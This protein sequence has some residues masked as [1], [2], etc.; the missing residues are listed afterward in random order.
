MFSRRFRDRLTA[1]TSSTASKGTTEPTTFT[2]KEPD[3]DLP[4]RD[5]YGPREEDRPDVAQQGKTYE[6]VVHP[7][8]TTGPSDAD[9]KRIFGFGPDDPNVRVRRVSCA[10]LHGR[11]QALQ[12]VLDEMEAMFDAPDL[13][14]PDPD[15]VTE[16]DKAIMDV[17]FEVVQ[18]VMRAMK[19]HGPMR[20]PHEGYAVLKEEVDELWDEIKSDRGHFATA[21][22]EAIQVAAMAMRYVLDLHR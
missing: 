8:E 18:E 11:P 19:K 1:G 3:L 4:L 5:K 9:I 21:R 12:D 16:Q 10:G 13:A 7:T 15:E 14:T 20:S 2:R 6:D 17:G 22:K